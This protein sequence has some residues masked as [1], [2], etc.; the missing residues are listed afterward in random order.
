[1]TREAWRTSCI[2]LLAVTC[3]AAAR[4]SDRSAQQ[5]YQLHCAVCHATGWLD[6]PVTGN[7]DAWRLRAEGGLEALLARTKTGVNSM[8][9][10]GTCLDCSDP[11]LLAV[12]E[13]IIEGGL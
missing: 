11:E 7:T 3:T 9:P 10:M 4:A 2:L 12:I 1:M 6:A 8:P 5:V 13:A